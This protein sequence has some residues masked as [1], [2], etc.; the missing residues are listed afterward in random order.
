MRGERAANASFRNP[1]LSPATRAFGQQVFESESGANYSLNVFLNSEP[2]TL[3][4]RAA[5]PR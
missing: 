5:Q 1:R 4:A 2:P 3:K